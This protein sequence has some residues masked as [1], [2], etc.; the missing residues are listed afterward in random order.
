M[1]ATRCSRHGLAVSP[2]SAQF[3]E[4]EAGKYGAGEGLLLSFTNIAEKDANAMAVRLKQA[5]G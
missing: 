4:Y 5:L 2:L 3:I 1:L